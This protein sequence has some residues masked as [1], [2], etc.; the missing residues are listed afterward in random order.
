MGIQLLVFS[1]TKMSVVQCIFAMT[2]VLNTGT[3]QDLKELTRRMHWGISEVLKSSRRLK[4]DMPSA[5][6]VCGSKC[7]KLL[8]EKMVKMFKGMEDGGCFMGGCG[9]EEQA[10]VKKNC[11]DPGWMTQ[12]MQGKVKPPKACPQ[13]PAD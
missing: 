2:V 8:T 3:G 6:V 13:Q 4:T 1:P 7:W 11:T 10:V 9:E 5:S 12:L